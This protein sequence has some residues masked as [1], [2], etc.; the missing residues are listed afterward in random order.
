M[1]QNKSEEEYARAPRRVRQIKNVG[2]DVMMTCHNGICRLHFVGIASQRLG[3]AI[4]KYVDPKYIYIT[5][6][7][8]IMSTR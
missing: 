1:H 6:V 7:A 5:S 2:L 4:E 8:G 3:A